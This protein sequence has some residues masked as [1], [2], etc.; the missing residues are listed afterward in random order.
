MLKGRKWIAEESLALAQAWLDA[1]EEVGA[2]ALRGTGQDSNEFWDKVKAKFD[3][4]SPH[5][6]QGTYRERAT[7]AVQNQ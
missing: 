1:T 3:E 2:T 7:S 5:N 6:P 4:K